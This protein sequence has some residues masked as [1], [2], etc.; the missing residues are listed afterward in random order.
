MTADEVSPRSRFWRNLAL[1]LLLVGLA[2]R[3]LRY[4]L[5]FPIWG[6]EAFVCLNFLD[7]DFATLTGPLRFVQVAPILFLWTELAAYRMLGGSELALRLLPFLAGLGS[8]FLFWR[9]ARLTLSPRA[10]ALAVG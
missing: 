8:L 10:C 9:L 1:V 5:Q 4:F 3:A 7:R 2:W 6:D